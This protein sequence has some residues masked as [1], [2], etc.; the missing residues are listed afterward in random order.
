M[1]NVQTVSF[2]AIRTVAFGSVAATYA[3][4]GAALTHPVRLVC[5]TNNTNGDMFFSVNG[6]TDHLFVAGGSF[7]LFDLNTNR[8]NVDQWWVLQKNTQF[9]VRYNTVP[10]SGAVYI[11]CLWGE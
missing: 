11:E 5:I 8:S 2:D 1:S 6:S 4:I 7:K 9:Y 10:T 3:V